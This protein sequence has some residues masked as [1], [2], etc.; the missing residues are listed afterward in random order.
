MQM[1]RGGGAFQ[2]DSVDIS[3]AKMCFAKMKTDILKCISV[4]RAYV[5]IGIEETLKLAGT[6]I[7]LN[8]E[9][10]TRK[11]YSICDGPCSFSSDY[12]FSFILQVLQKLSSVCSLRCNESASSQTLL[13]QAV[14]SVTMSVASRQ[15]ENNLLNMI[16]IMLS[17]SIL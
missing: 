15:Q 12:L 8:T 1:G 3:F 16:S 6:N 9:P 14:N 2:N 7:P 13:C 4:D 17:V 5:I 11:F 10:N